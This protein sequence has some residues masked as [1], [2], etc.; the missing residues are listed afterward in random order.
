V[1]SQ[2]ALVALVVAVSVGCAGMPAGGRV[3]VGRAVPAAAGEVDIRA[4]P[5][6]P[7]PKMAPA[8]IVGGYLQ[9]LVNDDQ[10]YAIARSYLTPA[11][12]ESWNASAGITTYDD[13]SLVFP[14]TTAA[15]ASKRIVHMVARGIGHID[16][17]GDYQPAPI[18]M[19]P[20]FTVVL[21]ASGWRIDKL[22]AGVLLSAVDAQRSL[23]LFHVY[24][25][26]R[27]GSR[28][29]PEQLVLHNEQNGV[30]TALL[31][32]LLAGPG[33]WLAPAV[34]T[35]FP[36]G[37]TLIGNVPV[38]DSGVAEVNLSPA[39]RSASTREL[40]ALSAQIVWT[41]RQVTEITAVRIVA[42]SSP[43]SVPDAPARQPRTSW[44]SYDPLA[45]P[46][47]P[48]VLYVVN[49]HVRTLGTLGGDVGRVA[50]V[51]SNAVLSPDGQTLAVVRPEG[52]QQTLLVGPLAGRLAAVLA[53]HAL[54]PASYSPE[55]D[56]F[57]VAT[58]AHGRRLMEV[59]RKTR[60]V[61]QVKA[62]AD[63]LSQPVREL[64]L[65]RD[66]SRVAAVTGSRGDHLLVGRVTGS[67]SSLVFGG[68]R[69]IAAGLSDIRGLAWLG[70][71]EVVVTTGGPRL[72]QIVATDV[73]G[74]S[75]R[76]EST[77]QLRSS[78]VDIA[79]APGQP[80][81]VGTSTNQ[82]YAD[83]GGWQRIGPPGASAPSYPD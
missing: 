7:R 73:D 9:A 80:L 19:R 74:Y 1:R 46:R 70:A 26:S 27:D 42:D 10:N 24:Y 57:T 48:A 36:S 61:R 72:R 12:Q 34:G 83:I 47:T 15:G 44:Q 59:S 53:D 81:I 21:G 37:T 50:G 16:V 77:D 18:T 11:A 5:P 14:T 38:D 40:K 55:G 45:P 62:D 58:G 49:H 3:H 13:N 31:R 30:A 71:D 64:R 82:M 75:T 17:R 8:D 67:S 33:S 79:A 25:L 2:V 78:P 56:V 52:G 32:A 22:P 29:V 6:G 41:L 23:R 51:A 35:G 69:D 4:L 54:T 60:S 65:S 76:T 66:G 68:F 20:S 63:L 28:L 39:V 43:L